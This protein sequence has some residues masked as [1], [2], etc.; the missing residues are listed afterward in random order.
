MT[1]QS[2]TASG[3]ANEGKGD[4]QKKLCASIGG[5]ACQRS[6][7]QGNRRFG[8]AD[9]QFGKSAEKQPNTVMPIGRVE[10]HCPLD[11]G[12]CLPGIAEKGSIVP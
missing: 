11:R 4:Y 9:E 1:L 3:A 6:P 8:L 5:I 7:E 12:Q 2:T 10:A